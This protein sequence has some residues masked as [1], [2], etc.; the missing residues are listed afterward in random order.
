VVNAWQLGGAPGG[1][2]RLELYEL[3]ADTRAVL[4]EVFAAPGLQL[5]QVDVQILPEPEDGSAF[6]GELHIESSIAAWN[7]QDIVLL[8]PF[9]MW[10]QAQDQ[11]RRNRYRRII[12]RLIARGDESPSLLLFWTWG[13]AFPVADGDLNGTNTPVPN[14][15]QGLRDVLHQGNRRFIRVTW[16]WGLQF[17]MWVLVPEPYLDALCAAL[18]LRCDE[19]RD[20]L[21]QGGYQFTNPNID[22]VVD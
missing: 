19:V 10:R 5:P 6:D 17:A 18:Q 8:D 9:A 20:H 3:A 22:V 21:Q 14:G 15:Y 4:R 13:R 2:H 16:R 1:P 11:L 12:E 7:A